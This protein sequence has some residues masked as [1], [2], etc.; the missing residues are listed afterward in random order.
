MSKLVIWVI[1]YISMEKE[2]IKYVWLLTKNANPFSSL[3]IFSV[4]GLD[5]LG[6]FF[7]LGVLAPLREVFS[8]NVTYTIQPRSLLL[9]Q[10][11]AA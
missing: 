7:F 1:G 3:C 10:N 2:E 8:S 9:V 5:S 4:L 6:N 11:I